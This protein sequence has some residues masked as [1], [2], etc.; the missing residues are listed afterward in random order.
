MNV[1]CQIAQ[2]IAVLPAVLP[3]IHLSFTGQGWWLFCSGEKQPSQATSP[4]K[5]AVQLALAGR[6]GSHTPPNSTTPNKTNPQLPAVAPSQAPPAA[7]RQP[8]QQVA[9]QSSP[10]AE[11]AVSASASGAIVTPTGEESNKRKRCEDDNSAAPRPSNPAP[12]VPML[13][14]PVAPLDGRS[15]QHACMP[16]WVASIVVSSCTLVGLSFANPA[17]TGVCGACSPSGKPRAGGQ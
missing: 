7:A 11:Q 4:E 2:C 8:T 1:H 5:A 14:A 6:E 3:S 15:R 13:S 10:P 9:K 16:G 12:G 17:Q